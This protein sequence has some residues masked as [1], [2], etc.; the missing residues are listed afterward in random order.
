MDPKPF[1]D[2]IAKHQWVGLAALVIGLMVR[3]LK[4]DSTFPPFAIP[5]RWRPLLAMGL[6][7]VSGVLQA[8]STGTRWHDAILG[9]LVSAFVA[10]AGH[11]AIVGSIRDGKDVPLPGPMR[12]A[13]GQSK[14]PKPEPPTPVDPSVPR[15]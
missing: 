13:S 1:L 10:I 14:G 15:A 12:V 11:D 2:L 3:L 6:G 9:G 7:V 5:A 4:E 8:V